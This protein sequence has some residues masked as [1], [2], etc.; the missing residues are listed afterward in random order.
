MG[1]CYVASTRELPPVRAVDRSSAFVVAGYAVCLRD[2]VSWGS[3]EVLS[4]A[5]ATNRLQWCKAL[6]K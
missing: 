1:S 5:C 2:T 4:E 3:L 6:S